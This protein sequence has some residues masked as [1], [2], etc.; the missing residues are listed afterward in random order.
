MVAAAGAALSR[1]SLLT[2]AE[3]QRCGGV[4]RDRRRYPSDRCVHELFE[5]Q[6]AQGAGGRQRWCARTQRLSYGELNRRSNQLAHHLRG[7][8][9]GPEVRGRAVRRAL[10][11]RWWWG[12][13]GI[14]KAGGAYLP[15]DPSYPPE[16]LAYMLAGCARRWW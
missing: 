6:A 4:E 5:A 10:A 2:E 7:L 15:L 8:G 12:L 1:V 11:S 14:L 9:V 16:R 3:R 13:L